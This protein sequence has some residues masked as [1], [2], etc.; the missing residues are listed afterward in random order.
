M[1]HLDPTIYAALLSGTLPPKEARTLA[2]HLEGDCEACERF[3]AER[4]EADAL[5]GTTDA[6]VSG[7]FPPGRA[8]A[9]ND[10]EFARIQ[11]ALRGGTRPRRRALAPLAVAASLLVAGAAGLAWRQLR[12]PPAA[13]PAWDGLKGT[14]QRALPIRLRFL[15]LGAGGEVTKGLSGEPVDRR[16]SLLF[17]VEASREADVALARVGPGGAAELVW[18]SRVPGGRTQVTVGG[19]PAGYPLGALDGVQRF[20]LVAGEAGLDEG[21]ALRAA[22]ALAPPRGFHA[23]APALDGLTVDLVEV[24]VR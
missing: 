12:P 6:A 7:A 23:E 20:V 24:N 18:A 14:G 21:R 5:D 22:A 11:R 13:G 19:R 16:A 9:G 10:L 3:L 17:E 2:E 8:A 1:M 15:V 4:E